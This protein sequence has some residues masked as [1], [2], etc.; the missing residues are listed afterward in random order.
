MEEEK[1]IGVGD[2]D[3][4]ASEEG[5]SEYVRVLHAHYDDLG[6]Q[7]MNT[8]KKGEMIRVSREWE[9]I[10]RVRTGIHPHSN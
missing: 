2:D 8:R 4:D 6:G 7:R 3:D 1:E 5:K 9:E 10:Y